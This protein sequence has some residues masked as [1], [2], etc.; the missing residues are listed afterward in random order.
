MIMTDA[1]RPM[2]LGL[3]PARGGS[4]GIP[5][6]NIR[7]MAGKP[8]IAWTIEAALCS[9]RLDAVVVST[10]DEE[11]AEVSRAVGA[12]VPFIRPAELAADDT[13]GIDPVLHAMGM[14]PQYDAVLLLQPTSPLR[15][16][17]DIDGLLSLAA[18]TGAKSVVSVCEPE[19]H[20]F[21][22]YRLGTDRRLE[23]LIETPD[24]ARRQDLPPVFALNGA[25]YFA[26]VDCL[27]RRRGFVGAETLGYPMPVERSVDIDGPLDWRIA[28]LLLG[29]RVSGREAEAPR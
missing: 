25:M 9:T 2:T 5:R 17:E 29:D 14:L 3:I 10:D 11:I 4:K 13:P 18:A 27:H 12:Q 24:I 19:D 6:K 28:E 8:L 23:R 20:P 26:H 7:L 1:A 21:W 16:T 22:M 15:T